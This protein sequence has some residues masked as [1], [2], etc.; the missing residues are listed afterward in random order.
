M[1]TAWDEQ[2]VA[3]DPFGMSRFSI[4]RY[5]VQHFLLIALTNALLI[6]LTVVASTHGYAPLI[7]LSAAALAVVLVKTVLVV[8]VGIRTVAVEI[9]IRRLGMGD[10]EYRI[11]P[12]GND[13][14]S[15]ACQ[16]LEALRQNSIR[17]MQLDL[18]T[19]LSAEIQERNSELEQA[20]ADLQDSQ[21]RIISQQKL[22]ELGE[23][24]AG[25]AHEMRNP[26]QFIGN[27][28]SSSQE[29]AA[30]LLELL[31]QSG[32]VDR[33]EAADLVGDLTGNLERVEHHSDRLTSI[34]S[35]MMIYDR[36][37]EGGFRP[38]VLN[39]L[40]V[41]Q[42]NLACQAVQ[43]CEPGFSTEISMELD[44]NL[45]EIVAVPEDVARVI[46]NLVMNACEAMA[47]KRRVEEVSYRPQLTVTTS[48]SDDAVAMTVRD[49]GTGLSRELMPRM[50]NPF[51]TTRGAGR[52]TGLGLSLV[53]DVV[54]AHGGSVEPVSDPGQYTEMK[55]LLPRQPVAAE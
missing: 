22:A 15:K 41:E 35:A 38:V 14:V 6:T 55:V 43:V 40:I 11:E 16:A 34:A 46:A 23:L 3:N 13:E 32:E 51:V 49:N 29:L 24:A 1:T 4:R 53:W 25:V 7:A 18:V 48:G 12:R 42:T 8:W 36:G 27:F 2:I 31:E 45:G 17:A 54:R 39:Q 20:L 52:N 5:S 50:F 21:D 9:W 44:P 10:L 26:L 30:E 19:Q 47:E 28:T 33:Q 37:T